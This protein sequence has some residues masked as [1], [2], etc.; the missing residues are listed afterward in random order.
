MTLVKD[1]NLLTPCTCQVL[2]SPLYLQPVAPY[3]PQRRLEPGGSSA[4]KQTFFI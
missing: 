1:P 2:C 4:L 3:R